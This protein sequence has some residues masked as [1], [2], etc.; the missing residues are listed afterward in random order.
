MAASA[1]RHLPVTRTISV[2]VVMPAEDLLDGRLASVRMPSSRAALKISGEPACGVTRR[3]DL[4]AHR[5]HLEDAVAADVAGLAAVQ[6]AAAALEAVGCSFS[7]GMRRA[8]ASSAVGRVLLDAVRA[9]LAHQALGQDADQGGGDQEVRDAQ[10]EQA[11]DRRRRVVGVQRG[12]H[13]VA[14]EGGLH[15]VL[16]GLG[17]ADLAHHDDVGVLAQHRAQRAGEGDLD[18]RP[19]RDLVEVLVHHLD[20]VLDGDDVDLGLG[21]VLEDRVERRGLAA[22]GRA[23]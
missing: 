18:L 1:R 10:V 16:R 11:R 19:H 12:E 20:R 23:R 9:D 15:R 2:V 3:A 6:A 5:Q 4:L 14:G 13:E 22:A 17:V 21:E 8:A 7:S